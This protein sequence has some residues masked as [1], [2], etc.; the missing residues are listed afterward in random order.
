M[1]ES[2]ENIRNESNKTAA[3]QYDIKPLHMSKQ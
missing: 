2:I 1:L 3:G